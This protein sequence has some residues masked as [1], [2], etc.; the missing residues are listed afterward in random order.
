MQSRLVVAILLAGLSSFPAD[1]S[2]SM[3][4]RYGQPISDPRGQP[5]SEAYLVSPGIVAS[6]RFGKS[7]HVCYVLVRPAEPTYPLNSRRNSISSRQM[8]EILDELVPLSQRGKQGITDLLDV[9]CA[10]TDSVCSGV[11]LDY[12]RLA[13]HRNGGGGSEQYATIRWKR[14]ECDFQ[15]FPHPDAP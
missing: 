15:A 2:R 10:N 6:A 9:H 8:G 11:I 5:G 4:E 7:E 13:V 14:A 12:E 1:T 3:R